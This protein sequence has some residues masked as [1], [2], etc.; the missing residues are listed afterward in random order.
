MRFGISSEQVSI[1]H[2]VVLLFF[3]DFFPKLIARE[4]VADIS[5]FEDFV[6]GVIASSIGDLIFLSFLFY[7]F[8][9]EIKGYFSK[10]KVCSSISYG[11]SLQ[12]IFLGAMVPIGYLSIQVNQ[13][14]FYEHWW[15]YKDIPIFNYAYL[16]F[17]SGINVE[18]ALFFLCITLVTPIIEEILYRLVGFSIFRRKYSASTSALLVALLFSIAHPTYFFFFFIFSLTLTFL[19]YKTGTVWTAIVAH[20]IYNALA[21]LDGHY[22]GIAMFKPARDVGDIDTWLIQG[23]FVP[24]ALI[25]TYLF[26]RNNR[27]AIKSFISDSPPA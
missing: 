22:L 2:L 21:F 19:I 24:L 3:F 12:V 13:E 26:F 7:V 5:P 11:V 23:L 14:F 1:W 9:S 10:P 6:D 25:L 17:P 18:K 16:L 8:G 20:G 15:N 4:Y 27:L